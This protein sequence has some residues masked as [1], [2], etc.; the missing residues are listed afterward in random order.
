M[1]VFFDYKSKKLLTDDMALQVLVADHSESISKA[2]YL[3]LED[4]AVKVQPITLDKLTRPS[5][6]LLPLEKDIVQMVNSFNPA[7]IFL[8]TLLAKINGYELAK[9]LK[10]DENIKSIP[11][12]LMYSSIT[13]IDEKKLKASHADDIL[14]KPFTQ[15]KLRYLVIKYLKIDSPPLGSIGEEVELPLIEDLKEDIMRQVQDTQ[16][17]LKSPDAASSESSQTSSVSDESLKPKRLINSELELKELQM[18]L[19]ELEGEE[20]FQQVTLFPSSNSN[21]SSKPETLSDDTD[22]TDDNMTD[23]SSIDFADISSKQKLESQHQTDTDI[24]DKKT[25]KPK[26]LP[27]L[28]NKKLSQSDSTYKNKT[29]HVNIPLKKKS[30]DDDLLQSDNSLKSK[31]ISQGIKEDSVTISSDEKISFTSQ[32]TKEDNRSKA[33]IKS[34]TLDESSEDSSDTAFRLDITAESVIE[35]E[36]DLQNLEPEEDEDHIDFSAASAAQVSESSQTDEKLNLKQSEKTQSQLEGI[37]RE[38]IKEIIREE[39]RKITQEQIQ[40]TLNKELPQMAK[41]LIK[42]EITRLLSE[43]K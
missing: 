19:S 36:I 3:S 30:T 16:S 33:S 34:S 22:D 35:D 7:I 39:V 11:I 32:E 29:T 15:E 18:S 23:F 5:G 21:T 13:G 2:I 37:S 20:D 25:S 6:A 14:E 28:F 31:D 38:D 10:S 40:R 24:P 12:I 26:V 43:Y 27:N 9:I 42:D 41:K 17:Y 4:L 8:D 1:D